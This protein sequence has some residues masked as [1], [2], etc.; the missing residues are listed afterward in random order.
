[1]FEL[2]EL[3]VVEE[4]LHLDVACVDFVLVQ[5]LQEAHD[6]ISGREF[7]Q[8]DQF[9]DVVPLNADFIRVARVDVVESND[10]TEQRLLEHVNCILLVAA[11][12]ITLEALQKVLLGLALALEF[13]V[14][15]TLELVEPGFDAA[16]LDVAQALDQLDCAQHQ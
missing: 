10:V 13:H 15:Q 8:V 16:V 9:D 14:D 4:S 7:L 11:L 1:V 2:L 6:V 3:A 12:T 5:T